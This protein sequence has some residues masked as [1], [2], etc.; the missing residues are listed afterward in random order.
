MNGHIIFNNFLSWRARKLND[1]AFVL[2]LSIITGF[3]AGIAAATLKVTIITVGDKL[4]SFYSDTDTIL[5]LIGFP[6]IE[7]SLRIF[8]HNGLRSPLNLCI[9][10]NLC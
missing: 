5:L 8:T 2:I 4:F 9:C 7:I 1:T 10:L 6:I 3:L